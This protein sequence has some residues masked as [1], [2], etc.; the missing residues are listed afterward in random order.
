MTPGNQPPSTPP[1]FGD[2]MVFVDESGDHG[3]DTCDPAYPVFVLAFCI[4][5]KSEYIDVITPAVQRFKFKHFGHDL[6]VLHEH[7]IKKA[8]GEFAFLL[9]PAKREAFF[10][11]LNALMATTPM[12]LVA[13]V[14]RKDKLKEQYH[15]PGNPYHLAL[16]YGLER[17]S[18]WLTSQGQAG[19]LTPL[20]CESRGRK[21]DDSLEL[22]FRRVATRVSGFD[23]HFV[24][25][26][27]NLPGLQIADLVARPIGRHVIDP[28]QENR[29]Y[30]I[31]ESKFRRS[32]EGQINGYGLKI[33]P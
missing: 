13:V 29:A 2:F 28:A 26:R 15:K 7:E 25:K 21:E 11:E 32:P 5:R 17:V 20:I 22:E 33:F 8:K 27:A 6:V 9:V 31:L 18:K 24:D 19:K 23:I 14:I 4:M 16:E 12:T 1:S 30:T 10:P 3:L